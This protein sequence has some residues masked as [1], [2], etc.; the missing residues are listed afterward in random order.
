MPP[1][2]LKRS[3]TA[4]AAPASLEDGEIA[5][6]QADGKLYYHTT[7][8]G[9]STFIAGSHK[10]TH[11]I[12]G[13]D[14]LT[15]ADIGALAVQSR[16]PRTVLALLAGAALALSGALMQAITRNPLA[17]PGIL[18]VNTGAA[19]AVVI[20]IAFFCIVA[21][22]PHSSIIHILKLELR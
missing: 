6:N 16:V 14:A 12:G 10:A 3:N 2:R 9:V 22:Y 17:D 4:G 13:S 18:G 21:F 7:A 20:G 1:P 19:L 5:I 11:A 8:G 15:P